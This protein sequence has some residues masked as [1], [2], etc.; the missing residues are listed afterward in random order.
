MDENNIL[1]FS[2]TRREAIEDGVLVDVTAMAKEAGFRFPIALTHAA[3]T[4][5]VCVPDGVSGQDE[6][7]RL[8]DVFTMLRQACCAARKDASTLSFDVLVFNDRTAL[9]PV[10]LKA[11]CGPD[12]DLSPCITVMLPEED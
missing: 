3:W 9:K 6:T 10:R 12:D 8:W 2:Y 11:I 7:G 4:T 1:I 5:C